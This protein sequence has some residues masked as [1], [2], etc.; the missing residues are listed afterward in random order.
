MY[1]VLFVDDDPNILQINRTY[2]EAREF[3]VSTADCINAAEELVRSQEFDCIV[4]DV[5]L[6]TGETGYN[7]CKFIRET[8][9]APILFLSGLTEKEFIYRGFN[10]GAEDYI[11]KPYD[12]QELF[13]RVSARISR[14]RGTPGQD[15]ILSQPPLQIN[16]T[17]R[18]ATW[19]GEPV[20]LTAV[21]FDIMALLAA[22]PGEPI[23]PNEIYN[24]VWKLPDINS[25]NTVHSHI[26]RLRVKL[27][28][29]SPEHRLIQTEWGR[30]YVFVPQPRK[31]Q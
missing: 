20:P 14:Y 15:H 21:E 9:P 25:V 3:Q 30:G 11:T 5:I 2:F 4:L 1:R 29:L 13:M 16:L 24:Q 19:N 17:S 18:R 26:S 23:S 28:R 12:L 22:H 10:V 6:P 31:P 27:D 7:L 8:T